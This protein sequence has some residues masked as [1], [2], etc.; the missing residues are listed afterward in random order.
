MSY[1]VKVAANGRLVLPAE[2]RARLGLQGGGE[3]TIIETDDGGFE[4]TTMRQVI[5]RIQRENR[6]L[7]GD[8]PGFTVDDFIAE[9]RAEAA[10]EEARYS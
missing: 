5:E 2:L 6:E 3:L 7:I 9:R 8:R 4:L 1:H 10:R